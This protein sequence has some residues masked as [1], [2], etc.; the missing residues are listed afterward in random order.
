[1]LRAVLD[2]NVVMAALRSRR[3]AS[4]SLMQRLGGNEFRISLSVPLVL[5]YE[6]AC[7]RSARE[8]GLTAADVDDV[9]D[10]LCSVAEPHEIYYLWRPFL[11]DPHDDHLLELAVASES[12]WIVTFNIR[13]FAGCGRFGVEAMTPRRFLEKLE[14]GK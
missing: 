6:E 8:T 9:V 4:Y 5:E 1:M 11:R 13:D 2:T 14:V 12:R 3:G 7:K 10:Y